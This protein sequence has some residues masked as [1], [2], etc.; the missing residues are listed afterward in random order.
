MSTCLWNAQG[1]LLCKDDNNNKQTVKE[2][3]VEHYR[4]VLAGRYLY[5]QKD[6]NDT[7]PGKCASFGG[8]NGNWLGGQKGANKCGCK[9]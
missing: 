9:N 8:W 5:S 3:P 1:E 2:A 7:C 4:D 6:A